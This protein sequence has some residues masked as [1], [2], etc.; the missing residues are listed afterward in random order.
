MQAPRK[1]N[2]SVPN[3]EHALHESPLSNSSPQNMESNDA[4]LSSMFGA[5]SQSLKTSTIKLTSSSAKLL[6]RKLGDEPVCGNILEKSQD[7][8]RS[9]KTD[10]LDKCKP[11]LKKKK[12]MFGNDLSGGKVEND[13][14][15]GDLKRSLS[16]KQDRMCVTLHD[17]HKAELHRTEVEN[18]RRKL[19]DSLDPKSDGNELDTRTQSACQRNNCESI[20]PSSETIETQEIPQPVDRTQTKRTR[21]TTTHCENKAKVQSKRKRM[22]VETSSSS[23]RSKQSDEPVGNDDKRTVQQLSSF[24]AFEFPEEEAAVAGQSE[25]NVQENA[26]LGA[27][28]G[29]SGDEVACKG[30]KK[31]KQSVS[32]A[33]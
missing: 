5:S 14:S 32:L 17:E 30:K 13:A 8:R 2:K 21:N 6:N 10:W 11:E 16:E 3:P 26:R 12:S 28:D 15:G 24:E 4:D 19:T 7:K 9:L 27:E 33:G 1:A 23:K 20:Q 22:E 18:S 29:G 31:M 25:E